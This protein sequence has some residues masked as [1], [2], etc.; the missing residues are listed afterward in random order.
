M[1]RTG[2]G[3]LSLVTLS[4]EAQNRTG[5]TLADTFLS[6]SLMCLALA[7]ALSLSQKPFSSTCASPSS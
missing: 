7:N 1:T 5:H 4:P 6:C 3:T 2:G